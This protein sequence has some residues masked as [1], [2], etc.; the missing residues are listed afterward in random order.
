MKFHSGKNQQKYS[1]NQKGSVLLL[2]IGGAIIVG[3]GGTLLFSSYQIAV[4]EQQRVENAVQAA[5]ASAACN[6]SNIVIADDRW[7]FVSLSDHPACGQ[8]TIAPDNEAL[9]ITGINAITGIVRTEKLLAQKLQ[10]ETLS[11]LAEDDYIEYKR[12]KTSLQSVLTRSISSSD[13]TPP[14]DMNGKFVQVYQSAYQSF[15]KNMPI[16][17][18]GKAR[19]KSFSLSL[20]WLDNGSTTNMP[21]PLRSELPVSDSRSCY[22]SFVDVPVGKDS[23]YFAGLSDQV[24]LVEAAKFREAD[25]KHLSSCVLVKAEIEILAPEDRP[26]KT[27][28]SR[29][30]TSF[31]AVAAALPYCEHNYSAPGAFVVYL[32]QG[33]VDQVTNLRDLLFKREL[34]RVRQNHSVANGDFPRDANAVLLPDQMASGSVPHSVG[35]ALFDW[36]RTGNGKAR[37]ESIVT[38]LNCPFQNNVPSSKTDI[39]ILYSISQLGEI[40]VATINDAG[41]QT[42]TVADKQTVDVAY[43]ALTTSKGSLCIEVRNQ[44]ANPGAKSGSKHGGQPLCAE[45]PL[46]FKE[47]LSEQELG[48]KPPHLLGQ[49]RDSYRKSGLAAAIELYFRPTGT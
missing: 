23:F 37:L 13:K 46:A 30:L 31:S 44:V 7:G 45:L 41:M 32:P 34:S 26:S 3:L 22:Q 1:R 27:G 12:L 49:V 5:A 40:K 2:A 11:N 21:N 10:S 35:R 18:S 42:K 4:M 6:L 38:A 33:S 36:L 9:P 28:K 8:A 47:F 43:D 25:E 48:K 39:A 16:L 15:L 29:V 20:G 24:R 14:K 19:I 17:K